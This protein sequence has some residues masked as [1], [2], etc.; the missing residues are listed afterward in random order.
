MFY[1]IVS[2]PK[3]GFTFTHSHLLPKRQVFN[4]FSLAESPRPSAHRGLATPHP[5]P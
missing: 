3:L 1:S 5:P 2:S 4:G